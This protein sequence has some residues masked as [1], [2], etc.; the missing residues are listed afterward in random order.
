M[1]QSTKRDTTASPRSRAVARSFSKVGMA[2]RRSPIFAATPPLHPRN[3]ASAPETWDPY[4][5]ASLPFFTRCCRTT[6]RQRALKTY[7]LKT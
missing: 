6:A 2:R 4:G 1:E 5:A 3:G 7:K